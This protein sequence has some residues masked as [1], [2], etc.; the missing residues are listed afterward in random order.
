MFHSS[1]S[2]TYHHNSSCSFK[3]AQNYPW[4]WGGK[5]CSFHCPLNIKAKLPAECNYFGFLIFSV[6][7]QEFSHLTLFL[8]AMGGISPYMSVTWQQ[9]VEIGLTRDLSQAKKKINKLSQGVHTRIH[10]DGMVT[11]PILK[12][13]PSN[14]TTIANVRPYKLLLIKIDKKD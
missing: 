14:S 7:F 9:T 11:R 1:T 6:A 13:R 12:P 3:Q 2:H 4:V 10:L 8:P 5:P